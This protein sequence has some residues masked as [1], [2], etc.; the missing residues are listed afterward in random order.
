MTLPLFDSPKESQPLP[1]TRLVAGVDENGLGPRLGPLLATCATLELATNYNEATLGDLG[2][3]LGIEDSKKSSGF[4]KMKKA[5]SLT[6]AL[7]H[8]ELGHTP[9]TMAEVVAALSERGVSVL[10]ARCPSKAEQKQ[11]WSTEVALPAFGGDLESGQVMLAGLEEAGVLVRRVRSRFACAKE[12]GDEL[13]AGNSKL[14]LDLLLFEALLLDAHKATGK[15]LLSFCGMVGGIRDYTSYFSEFKGAKAHEP[16]E[17][18]WT[19][20]GASAESEARDDKCYR[21]KVGVVRFEKKADARHL[22]V[23]LASM[24]GKYLRELSMARLNRF[25]QG[26]IEDL[27]PASG[28]H[29]SVTEVFVDQTAKLR[30]RLQIRDACFFR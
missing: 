22:P 25:Y 26:H 20:F 5:E 3:H 17:S 24:V 23:A 6:L 30:R 21:T 11:C 12:I 18:E 8:A 9:N 15:P 1:S 2:R 28:Y 10:K 19:S 29:D 7:L 14:K 16:A 4:S 27:R 13:S